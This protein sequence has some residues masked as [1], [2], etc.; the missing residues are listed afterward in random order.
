VTEEDFAETLSAVE[1]VGFE[2]AYTFKF[3][4][5]DGTPATRFPESARGMTA[6]CGSRSWG[7]NGRSAD[8]LHGDRAADEHVDVDGVVTL[9]VDHVGSMTGK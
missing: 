3:S 5:R 2:D 8:F 1:M 4:L 6:S 7:P 9:R